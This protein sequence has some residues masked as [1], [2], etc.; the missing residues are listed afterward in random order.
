[1]SVREES[2]RHSS[3]L[4]LN[5][6]SSEEIVTNIT[7]IGKV[8]RLQQCATPGGQLV[9]F[10]LDHRGNLQRALSPDD[11]QSVT[12]EQMVSFKV[13][14]TAAMSPV[15]SGILLDPQYGAAQSIAAGAIDNGC[16]LLVAVERTGYTGD[17]TARESRILPGWSVEKICRMG[18]DG[19]K[20][21]IY[22]HPDAP[23]AV[24]Q[25]EL[26]VEVGELCRQYDMPFFLEPLSFSLDPAVKKLA[27]ADKRIVVTET[28]RRLTPL[29]VDVLKAE[30]P[31]NIDDEKDESVWAEACAG[32]SEA[33]LCP[34]VILSAGVT[35]EEFE[36]QTFV[37]C[38]NGSSGVLVG[39][40]V[41][42]EAADL[43]G[44]ARQEFLQTIAVERMNRLTEA[45]EEYG[46]P[47]TDFHPDLARAVSEEW[48]KNY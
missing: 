32:V 9:M 2:G 42:A 31:I 37:A 28:A 36:R 34:W 39:R 11:P 48:Y 1:V 3:F 8:R 46:R 45:I 27:T 21:L 33:S 22:Y 12:Y 18:A 29:G 44:A 6:N 13:E 43:V 19:V 23:N 14:V 17:P 4:Y 30:F 24:E 5:F 10:A 40:A 16:G 47:W 7:T 26:V 38:R 25:E 15:A 35:F 41:W 20:L